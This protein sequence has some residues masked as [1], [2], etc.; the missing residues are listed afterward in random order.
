MCC[1]IQNNA[2]ERKALKWKAH[3][4][5]IQHHRLAK[6]CVLFMFHFDIKKRIKGLSLVCEC[7]TDGKRKAKMHLTPSIQHSDDTQQI[8]QR[9]NITLNSLSSTL[10]RIFTFSLHF[11]FNM[12]D[13]TKTLH[14]C[15][16]K[17]LVFSWKFLNETWEFWLQSGFRVKYQTWCDRNRHFFAKIESVWWLFIA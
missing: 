14:G 2:R 3:A 11:A 9:T 15:D 4:R 13:G 1:A 8:V 12:A 5:S 16:W 7:L 17:I 6:A 10:S